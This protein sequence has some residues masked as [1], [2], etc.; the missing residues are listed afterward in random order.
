MMKKNSTFQN[1]RKGPKFFKKKITMD[2]L[3]LKESA[4]LSRSRL[5]RITLC[6]TALFRFGFMAWSRRLKLLICQIISFNNIL[7]DVQSVYCRL[8]FYRTRC[9]HSIQ[10]S[11][12]EVFTLVN[13]VQIG[14]F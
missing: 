14:K 11:Y 7:T 4:D 13:L 1:R 12:Q 10:Q 3:S 2:I 9:N 6:G 5:V 8:I